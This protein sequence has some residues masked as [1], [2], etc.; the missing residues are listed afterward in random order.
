[1]STL[2]QFREGLSEAWDT[3]LEGWQKLYRRAEGAITRFTPA[4]QGSSGTSSQEARAIALRSTGW[5][6]LASEVFDDDDRIVVRLETPGMQ[7]EDFDLHIMKDYLVVRGR[8]QMEQE[9]TEGR[10]HVVECAYGSFERAIA[11]PDEVET[12]KASASYRRGIL[13]VELPKSALRNRKRIKVD[14]V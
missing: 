3:L 1:M 7:K 8:K 2:Q 13:R 14:V 9:R 12:D 11:L 4:T 5:G 10:Y 6:V